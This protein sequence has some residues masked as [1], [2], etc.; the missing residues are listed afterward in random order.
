MVWEFEI[1]RCKLVYIGWINKKVLW[2]RTG[3]QI[4]QP[5]TEEAR[6]SSPYPCLTLG[7]K[8]WTGELQKISELDFV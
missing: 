8:T 7:K 3:N 1:S 2:D 4:Q 5:V 6:V